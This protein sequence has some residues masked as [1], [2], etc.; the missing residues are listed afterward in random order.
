MSNTMNRMPRWLTASLVVPLLA[1]SC[2]TPSELES[3]E[4]ILYV[5]AYL[6]PGADPEVQVLETI[7]PDQFYDGLDRFVSGAEVVISTD[8]RVVTLSEAPLRAGSYT[9]GHA[10]LPVI[11]GQTYHL[12]VT[13]GERQL[14]AHTT[15]PQ[16]AE[17]TRV[18]GDTIVYRQIY[19]GLFGELIHPGEFYWTRS[20]NAAGYVITVEAVDVRSLSMTADPLTADLDSL[21]AQR[22]RAAEA[23]VDAD[24]L[25]AL[26]RRVEALEDYFEQNI[27]LVTAAGDTLQWLR[28]WQQEDWDEISEK[29]KWSE[30]KKW[31]ERREEL[32]WNRTTDYWMPADSTRSDFWWAGVRFA[33][34]YRVTIQAADTNYSDYNTTAFNGN[35]GADGDEGPVFHV[36]GGVGV[37]GSYSQDSFLVES[38]RED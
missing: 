32:Y 17:V 18:V 4:Q 27:S 33:G 13:D 28:D 22:D 35:S 6:T 7:P 30:G 2:D 36:D 24:S 8:D 12:E 14:R 19:G 38:V 37:F 25:V 3:P 9:V 11:E 21:L 20:P 1:L 15:V 10:A 26:D 16:R 29:E 5:Q 23:G 31:R 34:T